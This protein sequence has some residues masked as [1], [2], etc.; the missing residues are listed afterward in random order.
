M[1]ADRSLDPLESLDW[2]NA[3]SN[4][5]NCSFVFMTTRALLDF[6]INKFEPLLHPYLDAI[7]QDTTYSI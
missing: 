4:K 6:R 5:N 3:Y 7:V 1:L 2:S